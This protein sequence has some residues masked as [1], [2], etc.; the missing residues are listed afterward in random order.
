MHESDAPRRKSDASMAL[1][2]A[3]MSITTAQSCR[4]ADIGQEARGVVEFKVEPM[5]GLKILGG[6]LAGMGLGVVF[7]GG[8]VATDRGTQTA[9]T[10]DM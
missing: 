1:L 8:M 7:A 10:E 4:N 5:L 3:S 6:L 2:S 9:R